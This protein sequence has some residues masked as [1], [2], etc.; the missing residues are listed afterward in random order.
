MSDSVLM[1]KLLRKLDRL[2]DAILEL[3]ES[4]RLLAESTMQT[5]LD[6]QG[7]ENMDDP[8]VG[9]GIDMEGKPIRAS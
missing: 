2:A 8:D 1:G 4:N 3:A 5:Q 6:P 9:L 7:V